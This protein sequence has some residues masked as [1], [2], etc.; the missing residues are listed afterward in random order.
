MH[1]CAYIHIYTKIGLEFIIFEYKKTEL[2][3]G[4]RLEPEIQSLRVNI[5]ISSVLE[6]RL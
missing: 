3:A 2:I 4:F 1:L 5:H 6:S